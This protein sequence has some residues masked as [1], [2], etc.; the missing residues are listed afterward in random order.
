MST[1]AQAQP[2]A[3]QAQARPETGQEMVKEE[4]GTAQYYI[5]I[6]CSCQTCNKLYTPILKLL[7]CPLFPL[8]FLPI[9]TTIIPSSIFL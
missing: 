4:D 9:M 6:L 1:G 3:A 5:Y 7:S 2:A 8:V